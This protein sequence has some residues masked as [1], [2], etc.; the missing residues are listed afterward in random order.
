MQIG[1]GN[2]KF[3]ESDIFIDLQAVITPSN[4]CS[5]IVS[6]SIIGETCQVKHKKVRD[7]SLVEWN[8]PLITTLSMELSW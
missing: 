1:S 8:K 4:W 7:M 6:Q 3:A 5:G 2:A